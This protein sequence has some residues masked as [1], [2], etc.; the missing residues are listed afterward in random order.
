VIQT[1]HTTP[2]GG[3]SA[4]TPHRRDD[5]SFAKRI[6]QVVDVGRRDAEYSPEHARLVPAVSMVEVQGIRCEL[7]EDAPGVLSM[8]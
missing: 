3:V 7:L 2:C 6:G 8:R 1:P 5:Q 4:D